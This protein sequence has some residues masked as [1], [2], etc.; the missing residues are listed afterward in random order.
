MSNSEDK[1]ET[2]PEGNSQTTPDVETLLAEK[3]AI[4]ERYSASSTEAKRLAEA[5]KKAFERDVKL[6]EQDGSIFINI[7]DAD[8][9]HALS[10]AKHF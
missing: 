3:K 1:I 9:E 7:H 10:L 5:N 4:E 6:L 2:P 8:P